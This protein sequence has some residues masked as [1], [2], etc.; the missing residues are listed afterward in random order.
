ML[1]VDL[2][3]E[4]T[5]LG[6]QRG[7]L[8]L[9]VSGGRDSMV[10]LDLVE[11]VRPALDLEVV[12][13]HVNHGLR[14]AASDADEQ[15]VRLAAEAAGLAFYVRRVDPEQA[16]TGR[17]SRLRPTLEE[18]ARDLRR[19]AMIEMAD[20]SACD[21]IATAHHAG[22]Q[23]E[24]VL[25]R[26]LRGTGPDGL[27]GMSPGTAGDRWRRPL[28]RVLPDAIDDWAAAKGV[29]WREDESNAD[30][31]FTRNQLRLDVIPSLSRTFNPQLLRTLGDL[32]EAKRTDLEWI[33]ALVEEAAKER[34]EVE[35]TGIRFT[36][37]GWDSLPE[38]L[39]RRLVRRAL[40]DVGLGRDIS[41]AHLSRVLAFLRRGRRAGRD[42]SLELPG[43]M[44]LRRIDD[45]FQ[46]AAHRD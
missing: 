44:V 41:R 34:I 20:E 40:V 11:R 7:R 38:A 45:C 10:L 4:L 5:R 33:E 18:A 36:I 43:G 28:L 8:M 17:S 31:R 3:S 6:V 37:D 30:R 39:A 23:A 22:D 19:E 24:T 13:G 42:K 35:P 12:V 27:A 16:R 46:L 14:G 32:A 21:W 1:D 2:R 9:A 26:I 15:H 29:R 25:Q